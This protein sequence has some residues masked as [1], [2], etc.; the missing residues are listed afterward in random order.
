VAFNDNPGKIRETWCVWRI[1]F[2]FVRREL[3]QYCL[4]DSR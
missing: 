4:V 1:S 3:K 2:A